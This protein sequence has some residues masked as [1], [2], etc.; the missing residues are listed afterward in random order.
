[1]ELLQLRYF[2]NAAETEN[3]SLTAKKF[4]VPASNISQSI[5]RLERELQTVLF[6]RRANRI[7]LNEKGQAFYKKAKEALSLLDGA[8]NEVQ[9]DGK[10]GRIKICISCNRRI[11]MQVIEK[12]CA[13]YPDVDDM[14]PIQSMKNLTL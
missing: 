12:F 4:D 3:F 11:V 7:S 10:T 2:I 8:V 5:K 9:D 13:L 1:M 6:D 14:G